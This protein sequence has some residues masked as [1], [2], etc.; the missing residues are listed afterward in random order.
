MGKKINTT[1]FRLGVNKTWN[2]KWF[3]GKKDYS[4]VLHEDIKIRTAIRKKAKSAGV[5]KIDI[6][7]ESDKVTIN[8]VVGKPGVVIGRAGKD[9]EILKAEV[10]KLI[11]RPVQINIQEVPNPYLS[12]ALVVQNISEAIDK[13]VMPKVIMAQQIE[14]IMSA[15]ALGAKILINGIGKKK[16]VGEEKRVAGRVPLTTLRAD[17]DYASGEARNKNEDNRKMGIKVWIYLGEKLG[18]E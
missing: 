16:Q 5:H 17:I 18:T 11:S 3:A 6:I 14:K 13:R 4:T 10:S 9:I 1:G 8:L 12:S 15:G 7:R 2:S